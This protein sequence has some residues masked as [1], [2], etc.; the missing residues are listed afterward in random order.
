MRCL[1]LFG[2]FITLTLFSCKKNIA[3]ENPCANTQ[4]TK[5]DFVIEELVGGR[6]FE[7]DTIWCCNGVRFRPLQ[8]ADEYI[9]ILGEDTIKQKIAYKSIFPLKGWFDAILIIKRKPNNIC[10]P[11]DNGMDTLRRKFYVWPSNNDGTGT[12]PQY[13]DFPIYGTYY[14]YNQ[15]KPN[16]YFYVTIKDTF[17]KNGANQPAYVGI[18]NGI[19]YETNSFNKVLNNNSSLGGYLKGFSPKALSI[20]RNPL[21]GIPGKS[22]IIPRIEGYAW[23]K[24]DNI[25]QIIIEYAYSDSFYT[26]GIPLIHKD[27]F[28]G[29]RI[30]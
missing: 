11:N 12:P 29:N 23:I 13:P 19:P 14:G 25:N 6:Y 30:N 3:P 16:H 27:I 9:W 20:Y 26:P 24:R 28:T 21:T 8:E 18:L 5:A 17:W 7:G 2:L 22:S 10:F 1:V 15:S 4:E